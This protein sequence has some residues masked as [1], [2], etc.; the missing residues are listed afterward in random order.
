[1]N[2]F[3]KRAR[4]LLV[5]F[6]L[7]LLSLLIEERVMANTT[8]IWLDEAQTQALQFVE[9]VPQVVDIG[10]LQAEIAVFEQRL[11]DCLADIVSDAVILTAVQADLDAGKTPDEVFENLREL[12]DTRNLQQRQCDSI[13][14]QR[15]VLIQNR[16][17]ILGSIQ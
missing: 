5:K 12:L 13:K 15:D 7:W 3:I 2:Q 4:A 16:D 1:M 10:E 9:N 14:A 6:L 11:S 17:E 8:Y